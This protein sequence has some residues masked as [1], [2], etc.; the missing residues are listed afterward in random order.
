MRTKVL[1]FAIC[2][3]SLFHIE[4]SLSNRAVLLVVSFSILPK[5]VSRIDLEVVLGKDYIVLFTR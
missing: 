5:F 4:Q 2:C 3:Q 1:L